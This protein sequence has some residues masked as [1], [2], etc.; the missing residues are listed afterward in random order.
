MLMSLFIYLNITEIISWIYGNY[1]EFI[2]TLVSIA[3]V[4]LTTKQII[5]CWPISLVGLVLSMYVFFITHLYL[6]TLLQ[7]FYLGMTLYGWYNWKYGG[8]NNSV[9]NISRIKHKKDILRYLIIGLISIVICGYLFNKYTQDPLPWLDSITT[10][11]GIIATYI[12]AKKI[13]ENWIIWI[14]IDIILVGMCYYQKLYIFTFL[15]S[16]FI[17]LAV[18]GFFEWRKDLQ[19]I[20][21]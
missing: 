1:I 16:V 5:W 3:G 13:I 6:Q 14:A 4:Y 8:E 19:K 9:L 2:A 12:M 15:Y 11:S 17:I 21:A 18:Y 20:K 7:I 10:I